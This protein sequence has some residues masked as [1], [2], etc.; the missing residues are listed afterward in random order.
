MK[1]WKIENPDVT[2]S[3]TRVTVQA[4]HNP[5]DAKSHFDLIHDVARQSHSTI[6][7][8]ACSKPIWKRFSR[9]L[10]QTSMY[11]FPCWFWLRCPHWQR[12]PDSRSSANFFVTFEVHLENK[13]VFILE[14]RPPSHLNFMSKRQAADDQIRYRLTD[15]IGMLFI[16]S[17]CYLNNRHICRVLSFAKIVWR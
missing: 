2:E 15:L 11:S 6:Q 10:Q 4:W 17:S 5:L 7:Q 14:L 9:A 3:V 1:A 16:P 12:L 8:C 13:P